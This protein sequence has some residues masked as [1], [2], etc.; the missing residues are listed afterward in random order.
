MPNKKKIN[1]KI[2]KFIE[3]D[4]VI[5]T[6]EKIEKSRPLFCPVCKFSMSQY[7]DFSAY[8]IFECCDSCAKEWAE[9][10][11]DKWQEGWRPT[12]ADV[13]RFK[14]ERKMKINPDLS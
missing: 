1:G 2:F 5:I 10:Y 7:S 8:D 13:S 9:K 14:K 12:P 3:D 11:R 6:P 4:I